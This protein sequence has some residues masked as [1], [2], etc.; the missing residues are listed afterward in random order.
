VAHGETLGPRERGQIARAV[1]T[2]GELSG[3]TFSVFLGA[4]AGDARS[5]AERMHAGLADPASSVLVF[6]DPV[7]HHLEIVTGGQARRR[8]SDES[9]RL[10]VL[11]MQTAFADGDL[12]GGV[13]AGIHQLG[14]HARQ[15]GVTH[16][17]E[18]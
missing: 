1:R 5:F 6:V 7:R 13:V 15:P 12:V 9:C 10:A 2:A 14:E 4:S 8:L 3:L 16:S 11:T 18:P 17:D